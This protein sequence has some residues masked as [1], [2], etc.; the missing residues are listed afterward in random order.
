MHAQPERARLLERE[1]LHISTEMAAGVGGRSRGL[2]RLCI[3][4]AC[5]MALWMRWHVATFRVVGPIALVFTHSQSC[6]E[7]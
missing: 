7:R 6:E 3:P 2:S 5:R 1:G 4:A